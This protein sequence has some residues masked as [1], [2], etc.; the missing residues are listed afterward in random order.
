MYAK[1]ISYA[2]FRVW[3][4]VSIGMFSLMRTHPE[5]PRGSYSGRDEEITSLIRTSESLQVDRN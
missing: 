5:T 4:T 3:Y 1:C 2:F